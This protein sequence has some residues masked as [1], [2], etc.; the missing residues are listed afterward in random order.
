MRHARVIR[1]PFRLRNLGTLIGAKRLTVG[2]GARVDIFNNAILSIGD[3]VQLNDYVHIGCAESV[4]IGNN[5]LIASRVFITDHD[6]DYSNSNV[7]LKPI[8]W[9]LKTLSV[10]IGDN[11][12]IGENVS[13]LKGVNLGCGCIVG[14]NSVVTKSFPE[15]SVIVGSPARM[16]KKN[17]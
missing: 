2:V 10:S 9:P 5:V 14:A 11:T 1:L 7:N 16:L 6:H 12:W 15:N 3:D 17:N 4:H 8:E 13:I